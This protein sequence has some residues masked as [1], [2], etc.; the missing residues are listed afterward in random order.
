[1]FSAPFFLLFAAQERPCLLRFLCK[2]NSRRYLSNVLVLNFSVML[3]PNPLSDRISQIK[4]KTDLTKKQGII[5]YL[6]CGS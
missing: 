3:I 4:R 2:E 6:D 1:M 5:E